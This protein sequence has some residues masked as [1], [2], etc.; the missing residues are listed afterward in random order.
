MQLCPGMKL[1]MHS[2]KP[3]LIDMRIDLSRRNIGVAEHLL[4]NP[5]IG[6]I[7]EQMRRETMAEKVRVNVLLQ[8]G[9]PRVLLHD[10]PDTRRRYLAASFRKKNFAAATP[11]YKFGPLH[12]QIGHERFTCFSTYRHQ[13]GSVSFPSYTHNALFEIEILKPCVC[14]FGNAQA[15]CVKQLD[16]RAIAQSVNSFQVDAFQEL[17]H[18]QFI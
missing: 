18:L 2:F 5:Q 17:L 15:T 7:P 13:P 14:Q 16:H 1:P 11:F 6:A 4:N 3:L 8:P 10:L 9:A 12:R